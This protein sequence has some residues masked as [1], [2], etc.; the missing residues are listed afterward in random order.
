M[1]I[2]IHQPDYIPYMGYFYKIAHSDKFVFLD[3]CQFSNDNMHQWNRIKLPQGECR[4]K[5]PVEQHL[6]DK[7]NEVRTK[8]ELK[9]KQ[10]HLKTIEMNYSKV[11]NFKLLFT[12]FQELLLSPYPNLAEQ[13]IAINTWIAGKFGMK[14]EFFRSSEMKIDTLRE[15][16]V[17]DICNALDGDVYLSGNGARTYQK[18]E[19]FAVKGLRLQ[20]TDFA[21]IEY[22]QLWKGFIPNLSVLDY[23]F[24]CGFD[25]ESAEKRIRECRIRKQGR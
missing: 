6:G 3:D 23:V 19:D 13:N 16:R 5:I 9:W 7:I 10:K 4:L 15:E 14:T 2:S 25:W 21:G 17:L 22:P 18:E 1:I 12:E 24:N 20:Y 11:P 8:D